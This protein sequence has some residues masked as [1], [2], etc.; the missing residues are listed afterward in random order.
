M[1]TRR[2]RPSNLPSI[3]RNSQRHQVHRQD[4]PDRLRCNLG[5]AQNLDLYLTKAGD[6]H[7]GGDGFPAERRL[8]GRRLPLRQ[9]QRSEPRHLTFDPATG[10]L[11]ER[12]QQRP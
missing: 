10:N 3:Q 4:V 8:F 2:R 1:V 6:G 5:S 12:Q 9:R 11:A 7:L